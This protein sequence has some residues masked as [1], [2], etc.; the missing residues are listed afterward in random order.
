MVSKYHHS[1]LYPSLPMI[2]VLVYCG[3]SLP[4]ASLGVPSSKIENVARKGTHNLLRELVF[5]AEGSTCLACLRALERD[6]R[7]TAGVESVRVTNLW[8]PQLTIIYNSIVIDSKK[9]TD[10]AKRHEYVVTVE[11]DIKVDPKSMKNDL[12]HSNKLHNQGC[13][14]NAMR[15][16]SSSHN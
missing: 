10:V 11:K 16:S 14:H 4:Y 2:I 8:P 3:F 5:V 9:I 6:I 12:L 13:Q 7:Q 1:T 15:D